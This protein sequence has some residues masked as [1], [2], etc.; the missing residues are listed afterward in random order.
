MS[1]IKIYKPTLVSE[2]PLDIPQDEINYNKNLMD[3]TENGFI[4]MDVDKQV[5]IQRMSKDLYQ[6][7]SSGFR[8]L[9]A[10]EA[11]AC[12]Y[13]KKHYNA[14]PTIIITLNPE[15]RKIVIEGIDS[16]GMTSER[17][18]KV[19]TVLGHS[20]N[21][22]GSEV[23]QF[24]MGRAA[25][26]CLSDTMILETF[27]RESN[28]KYAVMGRNGLGYQ[29]INEPKMDSYGTRISMTLYKNIDYSKL[30]SMIESV[31][32]FSQIR[33]TLVLESDIN[34]YPTTLAGHYIM[35][36][37]S[38][39]Q[40]L[41]K[42]VVSRGYDSDNIHIP[43][44][45][46]NDIVRIDG[47]IDM[48][49]S[50]DW[51][52]ESSYN[53]YETYLV[54]VPIGALFELPFSAAIV[55]IKD[56][57]KTPPTPDRERLTEQSMDM[58]QDAIKDLV[59]QNQWLNLNNLQEFYSS[60]Y[61][62]ACEIL[63]NCKNGTFEERLLDTANKKTR[64]L[65]ELLSFEVY[66]EDKKKHVIADILKSQSEIFY[67]KKMDKS[68]ISA[69]HKMHPDCLIFRPITLN[70]TIIEIFEEFGVVSGEQYLETNNVK[71]TRIIQ[72]VSECIEHYS[73]ICDAGH[74][75]IPVLYSS[76]VPFANVGKN[77]IRVDAEFQMIKNIF[78]NVICS[79]KVVK[80]N[81]N[82]TSGIQFADFIATIKSKTYHTTRGDMTVED[83]AKSQNVYLFEYDDG[84]LASLLSNNDEELIIISNADELFEIAVWLMCKNNRDIFLKTDSIS[85]CALDKMEDMLSK[86]G[87]TRN[88]TV[89][90]NDYIVSWYNH[91][92]DIPKLMAI[93]DGVMTI[94]ND[95]MLE[96]FLDAAKKNQRYSGGQ[97]QNDVSTIQKHLVSAREIS[98]KLG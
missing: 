28:E 71:V 46:E 47:S 35:G 40:R 57:R 19:F 14:K 87:L 88:V 81:K 11:R 98:N 95:K 34:K 83:I 84:N 86:Y 51:R 60:K 54:N 48:Y 77:T 70:H 3:G 45:L 58:V 80:D 78:K 20:D 73:Q 29:I 94:S 41:D 1:E 56:E 74:S 31:S 96:L 21:F 76:R 93:L 36:P 66:G 7:A 63:A 38:Y 79:Y 8:E 52:F 12:R 89:D 92:D 2:Q 39:K 25:Y 91:V 97:M 49:K 68:K 13:A 6:F 16:T 30:Y 4:K 27:A 26:T 44:T 85:H 61:R 50:N 9:Y 15:T 90:M 62:V 5:A 55:T 37:I 43:I 32:R 42:L 22:D 53:S 67:M 17:F 24:G 69:I 23:G 82:L 64:N 10:N 33:T 75:T 59:R 18:R 72:K 65:I